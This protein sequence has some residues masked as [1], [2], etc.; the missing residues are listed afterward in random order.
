M[1]TIYCVSVDYGGADAYEEFAFTNESDRNELAL[2]F[3]QELEHANFNLNVKAWM[4]AY[5]P[6]PLVWETA[7]N[8]AIKES[9]GW[10]YA[11]H[12]GTWGMKLYE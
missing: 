1:K 12:V 7:V 8:H 2:S 4:D 9:E 5:P 11:Q 10:D 3:A 6:G